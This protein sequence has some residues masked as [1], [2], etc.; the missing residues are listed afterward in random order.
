ML[1]PAPTT[2]NSVILNSGIPLSAIQDQAESV[3]SY[4]LQNTY[5]QMLSSTLFDGIEFLV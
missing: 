2:N 3:I 1:A 4:N 5:S